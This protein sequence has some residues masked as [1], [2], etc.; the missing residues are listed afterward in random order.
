[1]SRSRKKYI[2][3]K[4]KTGRWYNKLIRRRNRVEVKQIPNLNDM[5]EY[6]ISQPYEL[7]NQ[8]DICDWRFV[9]DCCKDRYTPEEFRKY[10][11]K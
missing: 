3:V 1:M 4:D 10:C 8:W 7:V 11:C 5:L 6:N 2:I 9:L